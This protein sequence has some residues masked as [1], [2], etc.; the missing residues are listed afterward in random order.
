M[1][2]SQNT[3]LQVIEDELRAAKERVSALET[4]RAALSSSAIESAEPKP[5]D[6]IPDGTIYVGVSLSTGRPL[7]SMRKTAGSS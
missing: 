3:A 1:C 7:Y 2:K 4:A 6:I 5:G